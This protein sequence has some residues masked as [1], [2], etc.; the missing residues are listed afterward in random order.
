M[1]V[2]AIEDLLSWGSIPVTRAVILERVL[3]GKSAQGLHSEPHHPT[4]SFP[5]SSLLSGEFP[6]AC[7]SSEENGAVG[8]SWGSL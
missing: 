6:M 7:T 2:L 5:I 8:D 1:S 4:A 3:V